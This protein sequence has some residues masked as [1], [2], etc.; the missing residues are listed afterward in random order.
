LVRRGTGIRLSQRGVTLFEMLVVL[1]LI[2]LAVVIAAPVMQHGM[3]ATN[4]KATAKQIVYALRQTRATAI[5]SGSAAA[6]QV[7]VVAR[8]FVAPGG[9]PVAFPAGVDARLV[10]ST[11]DIRSDSVGLIRFHADGSANGGEVLLS[12]G[13]AVYAV[14]LDWV[15]GRAWV[16]ER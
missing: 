12:G 10:T 7:D 15:T 8:R 1:A 4:A 13:G 2:A 14:K 16:E 3:G 6:F 11:H 5:V 9:R